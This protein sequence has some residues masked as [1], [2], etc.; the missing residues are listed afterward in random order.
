MAKTR[1]S[2][3]EKSK[4]SK[5][6]AE[7]ESASGGDAQ[8]GKRKANVASPK[9]K[10][11][12]PDATKRRKI[13]AKS[14]ARTRSTSGDDEGD[15]DD[16][17]GVDEDEDCEQKAPVPNTDVIVAPTP[18]QVYLPIEK[19]VFDTWDELETYRKDFSRRTLCKIVVQNTDNIN[20]RNKKLGGGALATKHNIQPDY[21]PDDWKTW[22]RVYGCTH[23]WKDKDRGTGKRP[24]QRVFYTGCPWKFNAEVSRDPDG[25]RRWVVQVKC[26]FWY[27]NHDV[28]AASF[29][30]H[31]DQRKIP[32]WE[33]IMDDLRLMLRCGGKVIRIYEFIRDTTQ[34]PLKMTDVHNLVAKLRAEKRGG[35]DDVAVADWLMKFQLEDD[36]NCVGVFETP[37]S[38]TGVI[39]WASTH[40]RAMFDRFPEVLLVDC[41]HKTNKYVSRAGPQLLHTPSTSPQ[42]MW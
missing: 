36:A 24:K 20:C 13:R 29:L 22:R 21:I 34:Y 8:T 39:S 37:K 30:Q 35:S 11:A 9:A 6:A 32:E 31:P 10:V 18:K 26:P 14:P 42:P 41:T 4:A 16:G 17:G 15:D 28:S 23:G 25:S 3:Q 33:P 1:R 2:T 38:E 27:H 12:S 40:Q 19:D 7:A 5:Q